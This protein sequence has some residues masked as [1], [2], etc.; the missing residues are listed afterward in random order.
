[1]AGVL[2][3][4]LNSRLLEISPSWRSRSSTTITKLTLF[5]VFSLFLN[6]ILLAHISIPL[7]S[8][9]RYNII[10]QETNDWKMP[11]YE[12]A[13]DWNT[14]S[15]GQTLPTTAITTYYRKTVTYKYPLNNFALFEVGVF[16]RGAFIISVDGNEVF[17]WGIK[18]YV[19]LFK[20]YRVLVM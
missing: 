14:I 4:R 5:I 16:T 10:A 6:I 20:C 2:V 9:W 11:D 15:N 1:M 3:L 12:E 13:Q 8:P 19:L 18:K 17:R 7:G